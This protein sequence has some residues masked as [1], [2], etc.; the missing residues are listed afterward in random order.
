MARVQRRRHTPARRAKSPSPSPRL[1]LDAGSHAHSSSTASRSATAAACS[2][3]RRRPWLGG[4]LSTPRLARASG[5]TAA[6]N[7]RHDAEAP[8]RWVNTATA[9]PAASRLL[10]SVPP[11]MPTLIPAECASSS[12]GAEL[13]ERRKR[14]CNRA[15]SS[16]QPAGGSPA[17]GDARVPGSA[18]PGVG[19]DPGVEAGRGATG[20]SAASSE[21]CG[22]V[23]NPRVSGPRGSRACIPV[24]KAMDGAWE[25]GAGAKE[26]SGV[27]GVEWS[28]GCRGNWR[29]P[30]WP[31]ARG[32]REASAP[33][34][35]DHREVAGGY[36]GVGGGRS[37]A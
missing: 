2:L 33:I 28:E 37:T 20:Q 21:A 17:R 6:S 11:S 23:R 7:R 19:R 9:G 1:E 26:P 15:T 34:T 27:G 3:S 29:G 16:R 22:V 31:R 4:A 18:A 35:G 8:R 36:Q 14:R 10:R 12:S 5:S 30:R 25:P 13:T 32:V 24:A